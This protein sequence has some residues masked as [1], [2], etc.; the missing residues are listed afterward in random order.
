MLERN[1]NKPNYIEKKSTVKTRSTLG[2]QQARETRGGLDSEGIIKLRF[3]TIK[4][5]RIIID[6]IPKMI[7]TC[8]LVNKCIDISTE[9]D[10]FRIN[11]EIGNNK[12]NEN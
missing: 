8:K 5:Q 4:E 2:K 7:S 6:M 9:N 10:Y 11:S 3:R 12:I 1:E